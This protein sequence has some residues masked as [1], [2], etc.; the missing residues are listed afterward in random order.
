MKEFLDK[1]GLEVFYNELNKTFGPKE[2]IL[3]S[4]N[5]RQQMIDFDYENILGFDVDINNTIAVVGG[6]YVGI[7]RLA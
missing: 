7:S 1:Q 3:L 6:A 4:I 5:I 2:Q